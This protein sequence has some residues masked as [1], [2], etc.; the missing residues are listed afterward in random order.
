[1]ENKKPTGMHTSPNLYSL[2]FSSEQFI[3]SLKTAVVVGSVLNVINQWNGIFGD[4]ELIYNKLFFT[5]LV[6]YLVSAFAGATARLRH[7][8]DEKQNLSTQYCQTPFDI[9]QIDSSLES[10]IQMTQIATNVNKASK[11]RVVFVE[12]IAETAK[13]ACATNDDLINVAKNCKTELL[14]MGDHFKQVCNELSQLGGQIDISAKA[15]DSLKVELEDFLT[16]FKSIELLATEITAISDQTNLLALNAAVEAARAG[17]SGRGF[18]VVADEVKNLAAQ[19]KTNAIKI[20]DSLKSLKMRQKQLQSALSGLIGSMNDAKSFT[21]TG[22]SSMQISATAVSRSLEQG[23]A[24]LEQLRNS[25]SEESSNLIGL[26]DHV[27]QL[28]EDSRKAITGSANNMALGKE[29]QNKIT[30]IQIE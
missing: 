12:E 10:A 29:L 7:F 5:Y 15:S 8:S 2:M 30:S 20:D 26:A 28:A 17:D 18:A 13:Q 25:L 6:P 24:N 19:T 11:A 1:M 22:E 21:S 14:Q 23:D 4:S 16:E 27:E 9:K 3:S